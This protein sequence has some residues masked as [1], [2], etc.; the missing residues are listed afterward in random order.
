[1][2]KEFACFILMIVSAP[3][4]AQS[5][6]NEDFF[7]RK[8]TK[9]EVKVITLLADSFLT[10]LK[11]LYKLE[12]TQNSPR[13]YQPERIAIVRSYLL[14]YQNLEQACGVVSYSKNDISVMFGI[15]DSVSRVDKITQT[16]TWHYTALQKNYVRINNL[17]YVFYFKQNELVK[18]GRE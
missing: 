2:V 17:R 16:F 18:V 3:S 1:M 8:A 15:P 11:L 10:Q 13:K 12:V 7:R 6:N 4:F 14:L 5:S 9:Q